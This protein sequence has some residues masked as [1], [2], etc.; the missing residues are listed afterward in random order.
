MLKL[1]FLY[2][3][4]L[5]ERQFT[6][7]VYII[8]EGRVLLI[9]HR[10]LNKWLPPGGHLDANELPPECAIREAFEETGLKIELVLDENIH[11][12]EP[13]ASSFARPWMCLLEEIPAI[14]DQP[15]HQH[16]DFIYIGRPAGGEVTHNGD[17]THDIRWFTLDEVLKLRVEVEIFQ[18]TV[19]TIVTLLPAR[20]HHA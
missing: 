4:S 2:D 17:E 10:K 20:S 11:I 15:H 14:G 9:H 6:A 8:D 7:T 16:I 3:G 18:E 5:M 12:S 1:I 19:D 13:N